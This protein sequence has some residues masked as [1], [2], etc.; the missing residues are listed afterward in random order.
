M[1]QGFKDFIMRGNVIELATAVIIGSAF[2]AVVTAI[3]DHLISPIIAL[4]GGTNV[5]GFAYYLRE[6][7]DATLVDLGAIITAALNFLIVAAVVYFVFIAPMN[8]Y[9][10]VMARRQGVDPEEP[11]PTS[12]QLLAEIRDLLAEHRKQH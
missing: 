8:K 7:N 5:D 12:E 9:N 6:G 10:E 2:T 4:F 11:A 1:L 3:S